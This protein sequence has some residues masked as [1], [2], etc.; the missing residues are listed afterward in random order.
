M[1]SLHAA[2]HPLV[3]ALQDAFGT[4]VAEGA[5]DIITVEEDAEQDAAEVQA[6]DWTLHVEGWPVHEAWIAI[7]AEPESP[8]LLRTALESA[9]GEADIRALTDLDEAVSGDMS[10]ALTES[11]DELSM[12]LAAI[13]QADVEP[14]EEDWE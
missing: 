3:S 13:I 9:L 1:P 14:D 4:L 10:R 8:E 2:D 11:G 6:D 7:D 12:A 5:V